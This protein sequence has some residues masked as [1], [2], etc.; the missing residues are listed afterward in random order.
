MTEYAKGEVESADGTRVCFRR[1]G[2]GPVVVVVHGGMQA[3]QVFMRLAAAL[4]DAFEL[5]V[6]DR[7]G[8]GGRRA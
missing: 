7:R 5:I 6:P 3:S 2:A 1:L 8:R 4:S